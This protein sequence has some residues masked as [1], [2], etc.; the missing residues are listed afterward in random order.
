VRCA[1]C[2]EDSD[3]KL[4]VEGHEIAAHRTVLGARSPVFQAMFLHGMAER[5]DGAARFDDIPL[6]VFRQLLHFIYTGRCDFGKVEW[7]ETHT[8]TAGVT[9]SR[10][11]LSTTDRTSSGSGYGMK[12]VIEHK[13]EFKH[14]D[15]RKEHKSERFENKGERKHKDERKAPRTYKEA[16][17]E[18]VD[19]VS[20]LLAVADRFQL[21]DLVELCAVKLAQHVSNDNSKS[22]LLV[23]DA[24]GDRCAQLKVICVVPCGPCP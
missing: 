20:R 16:E 17:S 5:N 14:Q 9:V 12:N 22:L 15:E 21:P 10:A 23:A 11:P 4:L 6:G 2:V 7:S 1:C 24:Y 19:N 18:Y 8:R 13:G 3:I